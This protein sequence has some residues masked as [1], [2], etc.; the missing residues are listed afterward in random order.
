MKF[1]CLLF[2][3]ILGFGLVES[4]GR[5]DTVTLQVDTNGVVQF[6]GFFAANS[7]AINAV[8]VGGG[9]GVGTNGVSTATYS[10]GTNA[11]AVALLASIAATN[12]ATLTYLAANYLTT[13]AIAASYATAAGLSTATNTLASQIN[14]YVAANYLSL[15][16]ATNVYQTQTGL[17]NIL[18]NKLNFGLGTGY[19]YGPNGFSV[20]PI[21]TGT[22]LVYMYV[23]G[24]TNDPIIY[25]NAAA[26]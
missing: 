3:A 8:V 12:S 6:N 1:I 19:V 16:Q 21:Y 22:N 25:F 18:N 11:L 2:A 5:A 23:S 13:S 15:T 10:N 17:T 26:P 9:A 14:S 4:L 7:N 24:P 20:L